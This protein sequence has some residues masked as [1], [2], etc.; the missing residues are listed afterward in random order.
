MTLFYVA[1]AILILL[2]VVITALYWMDPIQ[3]SK[4]HTVSYIDRKLIVD[5]FFIVASFRSGSLNCELF[6][7]LNANQ[8]RKIFISELENN[9]FRG[10]TVNFCKIIDSFGFRG[11]LKKVLFSLD[12]ES[13]TYHP[14]QLREVD[15][16]KVN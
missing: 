7:Y 4:V 2:Y 12:S 14:D 3:S 1:S 9:V 6:E 11:E 5:E 13:V 15:S 16:V 8:K 10:R